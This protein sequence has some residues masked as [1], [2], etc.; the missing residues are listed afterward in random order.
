M[1]VTNCKSVISIDDYFCR[2]KLVISSI[3]VDN[4]TVCLANE[5]IFLP[6]IRKQKGTF[7]SMSASRSDFRSNGVSKV[8]CNTVLSCCWVP[9][10]LIGLRFLGAAPFT[11]KRNRKCSAFVLAS[12]NFLSTRKEYISIALSCTRYGGR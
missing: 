8:S 4:S 1:L 2:K 9:C 3:S 7:L 12:I 5:V 11:P 6:F 10:Q